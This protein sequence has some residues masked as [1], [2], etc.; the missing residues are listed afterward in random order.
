MV[1]DEILGNIIA[2]VASGV[3][4][5]TESTDNVVEIRR[6][7]EGR[8]DMSMK[9]STGRKMPPSLICLL[10][11]IRVVPVRSIRPPR[12]P[13]RNNRCR[14]ASVPHFTGAAWP[15]A[16]LRLSRHDPT[17]RN[18][19]DKSLS[20]ATFVPPLIQWLLEWID[21]GRRRACCI[22]QLSLDYCVS[23]LVVADSFPVDGFWP[24]SAPKYFSR[25]GGPWTNAA[26]R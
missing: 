12:R 22:K 14:G 17:Q 18:A 7:G 25:G 8:M 3:D 26:R 10:I 9:E 15:R 24:R 1:Y 20:R 5:S 19:I 4:E 11:G 2:S 13:F 6:I 21:T 16:Q 23:L